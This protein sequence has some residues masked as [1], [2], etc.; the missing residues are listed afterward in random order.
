M[1]HKRYNAPLKTRNDLVGEI[2]PMV[3]SDLGAPQNPHGPF[4]PAPWLPV[5]WQDTES[6]DWF[7]IS[8]G[9]I[10][11][12]TMLASEGWVVPAGLKDSWADAAGGATILTYTS[13]D[14]DLKVMDLTTGEEYATD[15]TTTYTKTQ[16][17]TALRARGVIGAADTPDEYI[18]EPVGCVLGDI[19]VWAGGRVAWNPAHL[20]FQ[21][22]QKQKGVQF[23]SFAQMV[24]PLV[25]ALHASV[26]VP[27]ITSGTAAIGNGEIHDVTDTIV[28][29]RYTD[30][31]NTDFVAWFLADYPIATDTDRTPL[32]SASTDFLVNEKKVQYAQYGSEKEAVTAAVN[33]LT[34]T[35]DY[36]VDYEVGVIFIYASGGA[37]IPANAVGDSITY[38]SYAAA[39]GTVERYA[40]AVGN[41][42]PG[43]WLMVDDNSN[44]QVWDAVTANQRIGR[45]VSVVTE[46]V[47]FMEYVRSAWAGT[48]F[49]AQQQMTGSASKGFS[50]QVT[51]SDAADKL[52]RV[53]LNVR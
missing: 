16:V 41:L 51:Y 21:N 27:A 52:V 39:P 4:M 44:F 29:E 19:Y 49:T 43:D 11:A 25:P 45:V 5:S 33:K 1:S 47:N 6:K 48:G 9:K 50:S 28:L 36:F 7:V 2:T 15:G 13:D 53:V 37:A 10:V 32:A 38:Y 12:L 14:Y 18:S 22:Y 24:L 23:T 35:G 8:S 20:K 26:D 34:T 46:P 30:I 31:T 40:C 3:F 42:K 17:Q